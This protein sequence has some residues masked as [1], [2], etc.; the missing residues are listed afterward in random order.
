[1]QALYLS[2][3]LDRIQHCNY[4]WRRRS[5][6]SR[7]NVARWRKLAR[8]SCCMC[9]TTAWCRSTYAATCT[10]IRR[11]TPSGCRPS[12]K[13]CSA[14]ICRGSVALTSTIL[15]AN[16]PMSTAGRWPLVHEVST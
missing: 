16:W 10:I 5:V 3:E 2:I 9:R 12:K 1:M 4:K 14:Q 6:G 11:S 15:P 13:A 7:T 8:D